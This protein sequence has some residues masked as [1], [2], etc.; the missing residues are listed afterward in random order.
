MNTFLTTRIPSA[1]KPSWAFTIGV[2]AR[3]TV[4]GTVSVAGKT[5]SFVTTKSSDLVAGAKQ[6]VADVQSGYRAG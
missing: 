2:F 4:V 3:R 6:A 1:S 5:G